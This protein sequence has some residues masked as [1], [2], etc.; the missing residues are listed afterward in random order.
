MK[1]AG[2]PDGI[3]RTLIFTYASQNAAEQ[4][5][6]PLIKEGLAEIGIDVEI[7]PMMWT[8]QWELM[9]SGAEE[10]Q[11]LGALLWWP[12]FNDAY[13][14]LSSLWATEKTP[15]F[16]FSYYSNPEF[17]S[18]IS[19]A[20]ATPDEDEALKLYKEAQTILIDEAASVY[21]F[22][23]K[24]AIPAREKVQGIK[25]NPSYPKVIFYYDI[26]KD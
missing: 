16:N 8:S 4:S 10:G 20:Y 21:L 18:L 23:V 15:F 5:F 2:Y 3:D 1:E 22:D 9:K 19:T 6:S 24:T 11:D 14:T 13:E 7:Q 12:T 25:I 26:W 17:D